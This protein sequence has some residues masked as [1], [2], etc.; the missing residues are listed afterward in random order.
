ML[1][2]GVKRCREAGCM[3]VPSV[4]V[5]PKVSGDTATYGSGVVCGSESTGVVAAVAAAA[6]EL[7]RFQYNRNSASSYVEMSPVGALWY[8]R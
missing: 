8:T 7:P 6:A 5:S 2:A 3:E 4:S 1:L